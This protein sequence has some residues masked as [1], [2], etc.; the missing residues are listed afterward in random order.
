MER[1]GFANDLLTHVGGNDEND[2]ALQLKRVVCL[3]G[4]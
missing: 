2:E 3:D 4:L 1:A